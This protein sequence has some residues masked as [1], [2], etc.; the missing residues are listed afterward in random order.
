METSRR[1]RIR[2]VIVTVYVGMTVC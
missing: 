1:A 2:I